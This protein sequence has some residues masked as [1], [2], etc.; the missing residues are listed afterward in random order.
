MAGDAGWS[1][2]AASYR[3]IARQVKR[4]RAD[5]VF[6]AG[7]LA[8]NGAR[9]VS[10]LRAV[11]GP[12][13]KL[14]ATGGFAVPV[15]KIGRPAEGMTVS[16][17]GIAPSALNRKGRRF[18]ETLETTLGDA[19][20]Q[21]AVYAGQATQLLLDAIARSDGTHPRL[22]RARAIRRPSTR[23]H[24]RRFRRH[25]NRRHDQ[26]P[27]HHLPRHR[28]T[29]QAR[30]RDHTRAEPDRPRIAA[31]RPRACA[32]T[33]SPRVDV[34]RHAARAPSS[35][36]RGATGQR[37]NRGAVLALGVA[38]DPAGLRTRSRRARARPGRRGAA[39]APCRRHRARSS[40]RRCGRGPP[41]SP[42]RRWSPRSRC[43]HRGR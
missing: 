38:P 1:E 26:Q 23:R 5:A 33:A 6:L 42:C 14:L 25:R 21:F 35:R 18:A 29:A 17:A 37:Q 41:A 3:D 30:A 43:R 12:G 39:F 27:H 22:G 32:L 8:A 4:S 19:P 15:Q 36:A 40:R 20:D 2:N 34:D 11:L 13:V 28:R 7:A 16:L 31:R 24:P 10:D 9:L